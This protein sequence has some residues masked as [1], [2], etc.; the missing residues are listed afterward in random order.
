MREVPALAIAA[1]SAVKCALL[2]CDI[3]VDF[4]HFCHRKWDKYSVIGKEVPLK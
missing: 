3:N 2:V 4:T 1:K